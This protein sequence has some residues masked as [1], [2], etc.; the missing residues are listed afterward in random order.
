M[1]NVF[2]VGKCFPACLLMIEDLSELALC[3]KPLGPDFFLFLFLNPSCYGPNLMGTVISCRWKC[4]QRYRKC[5]YCWIQGSF[6]QLWQ[7]D[8]GCFH[9]V[10]QCVSM[11][12]WLS[13]ILD[14]PAIA[15]VVLMFVRVWTDSVTTVACEVRGVGWRSYNCAGNMFCQLATVSNSVLMHWAPFVV[16]SVGGAWLHHSNS[17]MRFNAEQLSFHFSHLFFF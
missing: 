4:W 11:S 6:Y 17:T 3:W 12:W 8:W 13:V 16:I 10:S 7:H 2:A 1:L 14:I 5:K 15:Q 9:L